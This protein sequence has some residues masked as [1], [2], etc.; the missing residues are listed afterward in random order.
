MRLKLVWPRWSTRYAPLRQLDDTTP[1][2]STLRFRKYYNSKKQATIALC[3]MVARADRPPGR[4]P[5]RP[6]VSH[7]PGQTNVTNW[8]TD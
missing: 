8:P 3:A 1:D 2:R 4:P 6:S 7:A 5:V